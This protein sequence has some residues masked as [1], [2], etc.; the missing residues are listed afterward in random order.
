MITS[1]S[2]LLRMRNVWDKS[3]REIQNIRFVFNHFAFNR[4]IHE[5][6]WKNIAEEGR[7]QMTTWR[8]CIACWILKATTHTQNIY[9]LLLLYCN[10][11]CMNAP[12]YV[13]SLRTLSVLFFYVH[14]TD[15]KWTKYISKVNV[16]G[17]SYSAVNTLHLGQLIKVTESVVKQTTYMH[18][19]RLSPL[20]KWDRLSYAMLR[21]VD[22]CLR[23]FRDNLSVPFWRVKQGL[24]AAWPLEGVD[25]LSRNFGKKLPMCAAWHPEEQF[26]M[27]CQTWRQQDINP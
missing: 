8:M 17:D 3:C 11:A 2:V 13:V 16:N 20:C 6:T 12:Q 19:F 5:I 9:Y 14:I 21:R 18:D 7:P 1:R 24:E 27:P 4:A 23:T 25:S 26:S 22:R 10:N 15:R